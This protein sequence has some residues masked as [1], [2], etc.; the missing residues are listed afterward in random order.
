MTWL[1]DL[2]YW[3]KWSSPMTDRLGTVFQVRFN[4]R[5]RKLNMITPNHFTNMSN[6]LELTEGNKTDITNFRK[7]VLGE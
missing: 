6:Y 1:I 5:S 4:T 3:S 2:F 7:S